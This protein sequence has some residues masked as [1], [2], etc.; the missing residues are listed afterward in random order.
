MSG[1]D[2]AVSLYMG[3]ESNSKPQSRHGVEHLLALVCAGPYDG[4]GATE[5]IAD[6]YDLTGPNRTKADHHDAL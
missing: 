1:G 5:D 6:G 4:H 2:E 3:C